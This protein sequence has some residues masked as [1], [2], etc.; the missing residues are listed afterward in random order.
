MYRL[1]KIAAL[2]SV[3]LAVGVVDVN[4]G[5]SITLPLPITAQDAAAMLPSGA[6]TVEFL[7]GIIAGVL[8]GEFARV[9][10]RWC[11]TVWNASLNW[12]THALRYGSVAALLI[13]L[14]LFI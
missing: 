1:V 14:I 8:L 5:G 4:A 3:F 7:A 11:T 2:T 6:R 9:V 10:W 13:A 12:G